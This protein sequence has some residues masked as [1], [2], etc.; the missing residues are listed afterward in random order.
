NFSNAGTVIAGNTTTQ[1]ASYQFTDISA[2]QL[3][4]SKLYYRL[5]MNDKDGKQA[6]SKT[7]AINI[8][9]AGTFTVF[10]NPVKD[11]V[12]IVFNTSMQQCTIRITDQQGKAVQQLQLSNVQQGTNYHVNSAM[13]K[14]GV[15]YLQVISESGIQSMKLLKN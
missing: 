8:I 5:Q 9:S 1:K 4:Y 6:Y 14:P 7:L 3:G 15:Y 11:M 13:L 2:A 12:N 10:P